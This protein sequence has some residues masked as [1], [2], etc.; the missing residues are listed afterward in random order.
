MTGKSCH[1]LRQNGF[2]S[3]L[4]WHKSVPKISHIVK[5]QPE[6]FIEYH[7]R[8]LAHQKTK[9]KALVSHLLVSDKTSNQNLLS[10][11]N[12]DLKCIAS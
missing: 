4:Q 10:V 6:C 9:K 12:V 1:M 11:C 5:F 8:L 3:S 2:V 7:D